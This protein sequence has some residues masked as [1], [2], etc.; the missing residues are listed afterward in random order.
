MP[1]KS[2]TLAA[3]LGERR[4][5]SS[6]STRA[7]TMATQEE[8][9]ARKRAAPPHTHNLHHRYT[10]THTHTHTTPS[11]APVVSLDTIPH[12]Y[13]VVFRGSPHP[14]PPP[15]PLLP[16]TH[17]AH[18]VNLPSIEPQNRLPD[19]QNM[20]HLQPPP[21]NTT[22]PPLPHPHTISAPIETAFESHKHPPRHTQPAPLAAPTHKHKPPTLL[23]PTH[24]QRTNS[25]CPRSSHMAG[26]PT[27]TTCNTC[28]P[29]PQMQHINITTTYIN[30]IS[31][32]Q[33][34]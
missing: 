16:P 26:S 32:V 5:T 8:R 1:L 20:Q 2:L 31:V 29:H 34:V 19:I 18:P 10:H 33:I 30:T 22:P 15:P 25:I 21:T 11:H 17:S 14:Q 6:S 9:A 24:P 27:L 4:G 23:P 13:I 12:G 28:S 3:R 7:D